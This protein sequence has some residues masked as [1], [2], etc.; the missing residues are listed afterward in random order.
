MKVSLSLKVDLRLLALLTLL[1]PNAKHLINLKGSH[2]LLTK[3][4]FSTIVEQ[5]FIKRL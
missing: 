4:D 3:Y 5:A 2:R 1:Y